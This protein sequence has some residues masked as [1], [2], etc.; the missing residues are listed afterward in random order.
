MKFDFT[1]FAVDGYRTLLSFLPSGCN[2]P[3]RISIKALLLA[4]VLGFFP[5]QQVS[6]NDH[7]PVAGKELPQQEISSDSSSELDFTVYLR[8][9]ALFKSELFVDPG[10]EDLID[11]IDVSVGIDIYYRRFFIETNNQAN[12]SNRSTSIGYRLVDDT[13]YQ[14]DFLIGQ[15]YL[16]ALSEKE[17]NVIRDEPSSELEGIRDRSFEINQGFRLSKYSNDHAWWV[18]VAGDPL[19]ISHGGWVIDGYYVQRFHV[20]N[21][22]LHAGVGATFFSEQVVDYHAGVSFYESTA[23]R[24]VYKAEI[25]NRYSLDLS[26]QYPLSRDWLFVSGFTYKHFSK[27]FSDSP[28]YKSN[29]QILF[30]LG[31]MYVW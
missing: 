20:Y 17:G 30:S 10:Q 22:E 5:H 11:F 3:G 25:G 18:D 19:F 2:V 26:A 21:W 16:D 24:P 7:G 12:Q 9:D 13:D 4:T 14:F 27:S 1:E 15:S 23:N 6:A 28:L 29:K 8:M 31:V